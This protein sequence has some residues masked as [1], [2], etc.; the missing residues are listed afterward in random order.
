MLLFERMYGS[1]SCSVKALGKADLDHVGRNKSRN[2]EHIYKKAMSVY[3][4]LR[5]LIL[6]TA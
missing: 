4:L 1:E 5:V 3:Y 2:Q 6:Q